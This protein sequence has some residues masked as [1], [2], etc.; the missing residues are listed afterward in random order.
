M[1]IIAYIIATI[2]LGIGTAIYLV[3]KINSKIIEAKNAINREF[4]AAFLEFGNITSGSTKEEEMLKASIR[5]LKKLHCSSIK[6]LYFILSIEFIVR[7]ILPISILLLIGQ[8]ALLY[9]GSAV[10]PKEQIF[11]RVF[12]MIIFPI[13][14]LSIQIMFLIKMIAF[15]KYL[16]EIKSNYN[17]LDY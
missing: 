6:D 1:D 11:Y 14:I 12:I 7:F 10:L 17:N 15:E 16:E 13:A 9:F 4:E 2:N 5:R 8:G 3:R